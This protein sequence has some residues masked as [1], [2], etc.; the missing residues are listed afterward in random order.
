[1]AC[2]SGH[3]GSEL[4]PY[5]LGCVFAFPFNAGSRWSRRQDGQVARWHR[6]WWLGGLSQLGSFSPWGPGLQGRS[7]SFCSWD[8]ETLQ[9]QMFFLGLL[10]MARQIQ[11]KLEGESSVQPAVQSVSQ[12]RPGFPQ[13]WAGH[14]G[15]CCCGGAE[16]QCHL[17]S[18]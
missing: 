3:S 1:M 7:P 14:L 15:M 12:G 9:D 13:E 17:R 8:Q 6:L 16:H 5:V 2:V 10:K 4:G 18:W 11:I